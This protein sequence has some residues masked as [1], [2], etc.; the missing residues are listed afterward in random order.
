MSAHDVWTWERRTLT[1]L[2]DERATKLDNIDVEL[3]TSGAL[4]FVKLL[5]DYTLTFDLCIP[6]GRISY[7]LGNLDVSAYELFVFGQLYVL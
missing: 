4:Q 3:S 6:Q 7:F 1:N 5:R 2:P